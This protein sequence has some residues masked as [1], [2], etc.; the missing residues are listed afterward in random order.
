MIGYQKGTDPLLLESGSLYDYSTF[1]KTTNLISRV[2]AFSGE[3][4]VDH[5]R[6]AGHRIFHSFWNC[7]GETTRI[8]AVAECIIRSSADVPTFS[9]A[10]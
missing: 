10:G 6:Y 8:I 7:C 9:I 3:Q 2:F 4:I 1:S 5:G